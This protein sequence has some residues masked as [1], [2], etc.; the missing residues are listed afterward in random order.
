MCAGTPWVASHLLFLL[1]TPQLNQHGQT[2][3][4][5]SKYTAHRMNGWLPAKGVTQNKQH[6]YRKQKNPFS[7][8]EFFFSKAAKEA[9]IN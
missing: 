5:N 9:R 1:A 7:T 4:T 8:Q 3:E 6:Q 2:Q